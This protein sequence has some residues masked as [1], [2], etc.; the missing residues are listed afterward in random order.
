MPQTMKNPIAL[1]MISALALATWACSDDDDKDPMPIEVDYE[2]PSR[3]SE[4]GEITLAGGEG[5]AGTDNGQVV[6]YDAATLQ[7]Q[8]AVNVG[9]LPDMVTFSPDGAYAVVAN[10]GEPDDNYT[11]DPEGSISVITMSD[12][13]VSTLGFSSFAG[14][15]SSLEADGLR[16]FGP[17]ASFAQDI[18]PEYITVSDDSRTAWVSLQENNAIARIDLITMTMTD[19]FPLGTKDFSAGPDLFDVSDEDNTLQT[20]AWPVKS[21]Y[22]P[23]ALASFTLEG[24]SYVISANEGDARDYDGYSEEARVEDVILDPAVF[25]DAATLQ[26]PGQLGRLKITLAQ[27]NTDSDEE[28]E[29]LYAYGGRSFSI[30]NGATGE[31]V[32]DS[33][34]D[35][36]VKVQENSSLYPDGRSDDKG[37]E[38]EGVTVGKIEDRMIAF[39][40]L[41]RADV[42]LIYDV[43]TPS[44]P[45]YLQLLEVGDAPEGLLFIPAADSPTGHSLLVVSSEDDGVVKVFQVGI[46]LI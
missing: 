31:Q 17:N 23:D 1:L 45:S 28:Y 46:S 8:Q 14:D 4:I 19:V 26:Q 9:P 2:D 40:G 20:N 30:W 39:I 13:S 5:A 34:N 35:T 7:M 22:M 43:T 21:Y 15:Q 42:V 10:E 36:E 11:I 18:E 25:T 12:Y 6:F 32:Y 27:G 29:E 44:S 37:T 38:P 3:F 24:V 16:I 41:E 33:G